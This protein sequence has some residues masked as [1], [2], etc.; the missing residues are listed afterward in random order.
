VARIRTIKP[1][2]FRHADLYEAERET[3]L[4]LRIAFAGLWTAADRDGR[5]K[6]K[7]RELKL[8]CLP[9]DEVDFSR[10]L[11]ALTTRG[12]LVRYAVEGVEYGAIPTWGTH[13]IINN[14]E[15]P[16][17]LPAPNEN[18][19]LT[20]GARVPDATTTPLEGKGREGER[21]IDSEAKASGAEAPPDPAIPEREYFER[22][23]EVL[24][25]GAGAM[26]ANLLK[27][28]GRNVALA[29]AAMEQ[30]STKS[31]PMEYVA[32]ICR[33]PPMSAKPLTEFQIKQ[34]K[35]NDVTEQLRLSAIAERSSGTADRLLSDDHGQ[36]SGDL[37]GGPGSHV[38]AISG[39]PH[40]GSG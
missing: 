28:K 35:T 7:P 6:W 26:I 11:D 29:R 17:K 33:G 15:T 16:S 27:A 13:Q 8:D 14:R 21:N 22:G 30:A 4:P 32:A 24:G 40:R 31:D 10:V 9:H 23:R 12:W 1:E 5:F 37:R 20:R 36:R 2:F 19:T 38:L 39:A 34:R 3:G 25:K 18:N